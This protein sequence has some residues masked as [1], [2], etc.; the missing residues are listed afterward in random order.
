MKSGVKR[1]AITLL[2]SVMTVNLSFSN[3]PGGGTGTGANVT[4]TDNGTTVVLNNGIVSITIN[5]TSATITNYTYK[6]TN[7][8]AGGSSGGQ[9]YWTWNMPNLGGPSGTYTLTA[10][11]ANN[12]GDYAEVRIHSVWSGDSADAA[13]DVDI[14]YSLPRGAQGFYA[15]GMINHPANYPDN[16]GGEWRSNAYVGSTFNWLI[17]DSLRNQQIPGLN[18]ASV[19]VTGAPKEVVQYTAGV[20]SGKYFCK[21]S[22]SAD[23]GDLDTY[24]WTSPSKHLGIWMTFPS[25]EYYN[26]GPMKRELTGH[27]GNTLLNMLGGQHYGMGNAFDMAAGTAMQK[28]F[29]PFFVYANSYSGATTDPIQ[30]VANTL[31]A[32]AKSQAAAEQAAWPYTWFK[33]ANYVQESGRGTVTGTLKVTDTQNAKASSSG[34][35]IGLAP[36]DNGTDFQFQARTFQYWVKTDANGNFTIPHVIAGTYNLWAFGGKN[37]GTFEQKNMAVAAGKTLGLGTVTWAVS[38]L[39]PTVW[40]IGIPDRDSHEFMD[41]AYNYTQWQTYLDIQAMAPNGPTYTVGTSNYA[42]DWY[43]GQIGAS[44]WTI[45]FTLPA[46]P[47]AGS[48]ASLYLAFASS[49][50]THLNVTANGT[51]VAS[52]VPGNGADAVV[53]L[54]SHGAFYD[55]RIPITAAQLKK[56]A[57]TIVLEQLKGTIEFDYVR[58]EASVPGIVTGLDDESSL[59]MNGITAYPNPFSGTI[60]LQAA[61]NFDYSVYD[62]TGNVVEKGQG[63]NREWIGSSLSAGVYAVRIQTQLTIKTIHVLKK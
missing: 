45:D 11:P 20:D 33:N 29:G 50:G 43:Y 25:H 28:T 24:G 10:S 61:G 62:V 30:K 3:V 15:T 9:F 16:P 4:V 27:Q 22:M 42:K 2:A 56:G 17:V 39:Q 32:D 31:W 55:T 7:L 1:I 48:Q 63:E 19:A 13:M 36:E 34:V 38:R 14:Y 46:A 58:L 6:G 41:G 44:N 51:Q 47:T 37:I 59:D 57:N 23:L 54:G 21:Y 8:F 26:G 60:M 35:W 18:D 12:N 5:K 49:Y 40:E 52:F 53:R